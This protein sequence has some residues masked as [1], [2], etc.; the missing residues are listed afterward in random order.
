[1]VTLLPLATSGFATVRWHLRLDFRVTG[2][3]THGVCDE[4]AW[5]DVYTCVGA[6]R[7]P[8]QHGDSHEANAGHRGCNVQARPH[9]RRRRPCTCVTSEHV[10]QVHS[11]QSVSRARVVMTQGAGAQ[12]IGNVGRAHRPRWEGNPEPQRRDSC[13]RPS[14]SK[15]GC[16]VK[17][18]GAGTRGRPCATVPVATRQRRQRT[19]T[20]QSRS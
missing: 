13:V 12:D 4:T 18:R 16:A 17:S 5:V 7:G 6:Q 8:L 1:M 10:G 11:D 15:R 9:S 3:R 19:Q 14:Q 20:H 2:P